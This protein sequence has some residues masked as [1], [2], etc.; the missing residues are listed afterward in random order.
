M[1]Y[2]SFAKR[3][4]GGEPIQLYNYGEMCR[5]FTYIDDI[6][7]AMRRLVFCLPA[8]CGAG[9]SALRYKVYN[10]GGGCAEHLL[11][12]IKMLEKALGN[13]AVIEMCPIQPGDVHRT[14]ADT[15]DLEADFGFAPSVRIEEGLGRFVRW[16]REYYKLQGD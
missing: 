3:I 13:M 12:F 16:Y 8:S 11:F 5:D 7:S 1:A 9:G 14:F 2:F 6:T 4:L 15:S 10:I